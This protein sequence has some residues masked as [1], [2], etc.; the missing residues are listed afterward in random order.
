MP[1]LLNIDAGL[2]NPEERKC[3]FRHEIEV[4]DEVPFFLEYQSQEFLPKSRGLGASGK[5]YSQIGC[6]FDCRVL[7]VAFNYNGAMPWY[8]REY[9]RFVSLETKMFAKEQSTY[10]FLKQPVRGHTFVGNCIS[11]TFECQPNVF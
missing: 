1:L 10:I 6:H 7:T 2:L 9:F 3:L 4:M 11:R 5:A 8:L